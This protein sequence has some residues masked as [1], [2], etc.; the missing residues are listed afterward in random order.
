[1]KVL[2]I[3]PN[4]YSHDFMP[5]LSVAYLKGFI[6]EKTD[7]EAV[8][9]DLVYHRKDWKEYLLRRIKEE[10]PDIIGPSVLSFN[11][12]E[13]LMIAR[14][15]KE[16]FDIKIIFGGV[17]VILAPDEVIE[18]DQVDIISTGE[19]ELVLKELLDKSLDCKDV[20]GIWYKQGK[21]VVKNEKR[22]LI[23]NLDDL[24]FPDF[25]DF[26]LERYFVVNHDHLP[27]MG[28]RGCPF[29]CTFCSNHALKK[30][31]EGKYVRFRSAEN[32]IE[33]IELR[34]KQYKN[35]GL[36]FFYF[37]DDTFIFD[38]KFVLEFC[39]K[40][41]RKGFHKHFKWTANVRAN[42]VTEEIIKAMKDAGCYEVRMGVESGNDYI[43]NT[44]YNRNMSEEQLTNSF[45]IIKKYE[46]ELRLD[47]IIGAP[48]E[49]I[50]MMEE[51][52]ELAKKSGGD[53]VFFARLY[54]FPGTKIKNVC[55]KE[56]VIEENTRLGEKGMPPVDI[57]RFVSKKEL[58]QFARKISQLQVQGYMDQGFKLRG[59]P[60]LWDVFL[61]LLYYKHKYKLEFNQIYRWN[62]QNYKLD[63]L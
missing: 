5:C 39:K 58:R 53:R 56:H 51:S 3:V 46:L 35:R 33:E 59:L 47:F 36:R 11:F 43:R 20:K 6:N 8:V 44:V 38:K 16:N 24:P 15:I 49:T 52:L 63:K 17:H 9:V 30:N 23:S 40:Y 1:M 50:E 54:P 4:L 26:E 25:E 28:S 48:Y 61:F 34:I 21:K 37:F 13:G 7:H 2:L 19:G 18:N 42:L 14:F 12:P 57:T 10:K 60:F 31:L 62:V 29:N 22:R 27:I 32:V 55:E 45:K 41:V